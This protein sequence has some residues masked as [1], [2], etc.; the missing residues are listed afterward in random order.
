MI[1]QTNKIQHTQEEN[2]DQLSDEDLYDYLADEE[3]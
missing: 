3:L 1:T 2:I